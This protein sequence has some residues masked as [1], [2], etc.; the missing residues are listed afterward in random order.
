MVTANVAPAASI[1]APP[2]PLRERNFRL[3]FIGSTISLLGDQFYFV[4]MPWLI[5]QQT[6]SAVAMGTIMMAG[7]VPRTVLMLMGGAVSDRTSPR[8]IMMITAGTR[9]ILVTVLGG[10]ISLHLLHTWQLYAMAALFGTADAFDAPAGQAFIPFLVKPEQ[11]VA[12]ISV[13]QVRTQLSAGG[14]RYQ[15]AGDCVRVFF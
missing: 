14:I 6:G 7:A 12:A 11:L 5:L 15:S 2:H 13:S 1:P 9:A 4:A 10:L 3:L 8:R